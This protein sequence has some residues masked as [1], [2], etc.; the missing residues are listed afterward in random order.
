M[1]QVADLAELVFVFLLGFVGF[2]V[3]RHEL[4]RQ[5]VSLFEHLLTFF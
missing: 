3:E 5:L 1:D 2:L 4:D